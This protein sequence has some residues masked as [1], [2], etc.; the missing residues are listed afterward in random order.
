MV[1]Y[2][3]SVTLKNNQK[4]RGKLFVL[5]DTY[6]YVFMRIILFFFGIIRV[7]NVHL[8]ITD[9]FTDYAPV[10]DVRVAPLVVSNHVSFLDM[11]FYLQ[12][13]VSFL[14]KMDVAKVPILGLHSITR[15]CIFLNR[16]SEKERN[17]VLDLIKTRADRVLSHGDMSPLL[18]F[19]EG[20]VTNGR[21][22]MNFKKGAFCH[23]YPLKIYALKYSTD[24][25]LIPSLMNMAGAVS[26]F[27]CMNTLYNEITL[28][29]YD[30]HFD[31]E[32]VFKK[33]NLD[34]KDENAWEHVARHVKELMMFATGFRSTEDSFRGTL[35]F[36]KESLTFG[37]LS[38]NRI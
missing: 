14:S 21:I 13:N 37:K 26:A 17:V 30:D 20:T 16:G 19:P 32:W 34:K 31:P 1:I 29:Q 28:Y 6:G 11:F 22:L 15:Q 7:K 38:N 33:Y 18:I 27:I 5:L 25:V 24:R 4:P 35:E 8:K 2:C 3:L 23:G 10:Q 36:E 12:K 9:Y